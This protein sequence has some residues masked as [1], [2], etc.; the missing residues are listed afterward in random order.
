MADYGTYIR[1]I[2]NSSINWT[3]QSDTLSWGSWDKSPPSTLGP[4]TSTAGTGG[5]P[6]SFSIHASDSFAAGTEGNIT[7]TSSAKSAFTLYFDCPLHADNKGN[8]NN[9]IQ[10]ENESFAISWEAGTGLTDDG[11]TGWNLDHVPDSGEPL[12]FK[13]TISNVS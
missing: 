13:V 11:W 6:G 10:G 1:F 7:Y 4:N 3:K 5:D 9:V 8:V 2:N 12:F